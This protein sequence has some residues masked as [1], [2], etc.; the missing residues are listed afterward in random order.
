MLFSDLIDCLVGG[1]HPKALLFDTVS[2]LFDCLRQVI[3][4]DLLLQVLRQA[5]NI[6]FH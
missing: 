6:L 4:V 3:D 5:V 2:K 1:L